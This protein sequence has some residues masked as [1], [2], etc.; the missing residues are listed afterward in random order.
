[1][2]TF[3]S[4]NSIKISF[5][6]FDF[7]CVIFWLFYVYWFSWSLFDLRLFYLLRLKWLFE[8]IYLFIFMIW[9]GTWLLLVVFFS[10]VTNIFRDVGAGA[11]TLDGPYFEKIEDLLHVCLECADFVNA[12]NIVFN[13]NFIYIIV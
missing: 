3:V 1:M 7:I 13:L 11:T 10:I 5:V 6:N 2:S 8:F 12:R 9:L 4:I